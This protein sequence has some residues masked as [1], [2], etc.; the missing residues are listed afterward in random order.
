M[1]EHE[2]AVLRGILFRRCSL[3]GFVSSISMSFVSRAFAFIFAV[4]IVSVM[5]FISC[6]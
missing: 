2:R 5:V 1:M 3:L 4:W 6:Y